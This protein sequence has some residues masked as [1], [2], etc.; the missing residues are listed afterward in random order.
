[1]RMPSMFGLDPN[2]EAF[3]TEVISSLIRAGTTAI[4]L[5]AH[6]G[7]YSMVAGRY[8]SSTGRVLSIEPDPQNL[9]DLCRNV[10]AN[11]LKNV[12]VMA[13]AV[14][15]ESSVR[16][17]Y[18][19]GGNGGDNRLRQDPGEQRSSIHVLCLTLDQIASFAN[20]NAIEFVKIDVQGLETEVL[21]AS[22]QFLAN[23]LNLMMLVEYCPFDL[24]MSGSSKEQLLK[25]LF[26]NH[27]IVAAFDTGRSKLVVLKPGMVPFADPKDERNVLNLLCLRGNYTTS[28]PDSIRRMME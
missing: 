5:G 4:D 2:Y 21:L 19:D 23:S 3:E 24:R 17:L 28:L 25:L 13:C 16:R 11:N 14:A 27:F 7:H 10:G 12:D 22:K 6:T 18:L 9:V 26:D 20:S 8:V 1:M 15:G